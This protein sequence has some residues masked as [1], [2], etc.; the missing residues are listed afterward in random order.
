MA[1]RAATP[2]E[3][4]SHWQSR[5]T[6]VACWHYTPVPRAL[7]YRCACAR[8]CNFPGIVQRPRALS[9][10]SALACSIPDAENSAFLPARVLAPRRSTPPGS[11]RASM[12]FSRPTMDPCKV[13]APSA[14]RARRTREGRLSFAFAR[15]PLTHLRATGL[16][17][18]Q[19]RAL[20]TYVHPTNFAS[21]V[22]FS[23]TPLRDFRG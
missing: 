20:D 22:L 6:P 8:T 13:W 21:Q 11:P 3:V 7:Q 4:A 14:P 19:A 16:F 17:F 9:R 18:A 23:W 15:L 12:G 10:L 1:G 5:C 2:A